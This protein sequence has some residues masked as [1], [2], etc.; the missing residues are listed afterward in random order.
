MVCCVKLWLG[1]CLCNL[2]LVLMT[3]RCKVLCREELKKL[4][5]L[6][7]IMIG[8]YTCVLYEAYFLKFPGDLNHTSIQHQSHTLFFFFPSDFSPKQAE[9]HLPGLP[10]YIIFMC[11]RH[12]DYM[13]DDR[14]VKQ[15][16][17]G[18]ING[19]KK[20]VKVLQGIIYIIRG[21]RS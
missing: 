6:Y 20:T 5:A 15:L 8:E 2:G 19:I 1:H 3:K 18:V 13:N 12:A 14:K 7:F 4:P 11:I 21:Y 16:L 9:G 17:A 10:A